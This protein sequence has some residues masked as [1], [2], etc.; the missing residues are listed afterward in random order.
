[1]G[2][3]HTTRAILL[4]DFGI[5][6]LLGAFLVV[7]G[8]VNAFANPR[9]GLSLLAAGLV[10]LGLAEVGRRGARADATP[11]TL[12]VGPEEIGFERAGVIVD[13]VGRADVGVVTLEEGGRAGVVAV[14]VRSPDGGLIG[15]WQT[16][17]LGK[18]SIRPY[19]AL[20]RF[21]WPRAI[22]G[23]RGVHWASP[24]APAWVKDPSAAGDGGDQRSPWPPD[25]FT[26]GPRPPTGSPLPVSP[27]VSGDPT[28]PLELDLPAMWC[29]LSLDVEVDALRVPAEVDQR[30]ADQPDLAPARQALIDM[31]LGWAESARG[32]EAGLAAMRYD[33][34]AEFGMVMAT[35]LLFRILRDPERPIEEDL[36]AL[37]EGLTPAQPNDQHPP[38]L[39]EVDMSLG[40]CLRLEATRDPTEDPTRPQA[41]RF[42]LQHWIPLSGR[43][44]TLQFESTTSNL[45]YAPYIAAEV[46]AI[47]ASV[48][49][50]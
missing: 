1:V 41:P 31:F 44:V 6:V 11:L 27:A 25:P 18:G 23:P 8:V 35:L 34:D 20:R 24:D 4:F 49:L 48:T 29:P 9:L 40:R 21:G 47:V 30:I 43:N 16:G 14:T 45:A 17:W 42:V 32:L 50:T 7:A 36:A 12:V 15:R 19:R 33:D 5:F 2:P 3:P 38:R 22:D 46:D 10:V 26:P 28:L 13:R 37:R 39:R